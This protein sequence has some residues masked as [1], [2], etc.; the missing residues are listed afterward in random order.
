MSA[1]QPSEFDFEE[2]ARLA[3]ADP[4]AFE[5]RRREEI[6]RVIDARP[7]LRPRLEGLQFRLDGER[8]LAR[9]PLR[10]CL[11][12]SSLMW[13][14]FH[15]LKDRLDELAGVGSRRALTRQYQPPRPPSSDCVASTLPKTKPG[16]S[17]SWTSD[18]Q[19]KGFPVDFN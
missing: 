16:N 13:D 19:R 3:R 15:T 18:G 2:W 4:Q 11:R 12:M 6:R 5:E 17:C 9:T 14:S 1:F 10:A 7:D 8:Q